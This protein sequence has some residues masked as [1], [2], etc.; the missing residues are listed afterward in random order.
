MKSPTIHFFGALAVLA[1]VSSG[2]GVWY[3][4]VSHK[5][6]Y[7]ANV[8]QQI[9]DANK[10]VSRIASARAA[11][12]EIANDEAQVKSYFVPESGVV[13]FI[14]TLERLGTAQNSR[15]SVLSVSTA[16]STAQPILVLSLSIKGT[17]DAVMRTVGAI[18]YAP[19]DLSVSRLSVGQDDK[20]LW[21]A[22]LSLSVGSAPAATSTSTTH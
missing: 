12:A 9:D 3:S 11:L 5:S 8:Q 18:E 19:Y 2:Y 6:Q 13:A 7:V 22:D 21:H 4:V 16:G 17:F 10:N 1:L 20:N 14:T 15:V